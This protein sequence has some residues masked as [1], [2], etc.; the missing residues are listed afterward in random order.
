MTDTS[1]GDT[2]T[3]QAERNHAEQD[4]GLDQ[5]AVG[6]KPRAGEDDLRVHF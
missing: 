2:H 4:D 3:D 5:T 1:P 6:T